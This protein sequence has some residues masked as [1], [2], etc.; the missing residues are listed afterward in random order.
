MSK[1]I[2]KIVTLSA[3][4]DEQGYLKFEFDFLNIFTVV[5]IISHG[6]Q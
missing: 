2:C 4:E 6:Q 1:I 5:S 3:K